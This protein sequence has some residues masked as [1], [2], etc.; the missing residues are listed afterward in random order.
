MGGLIGDKEFGFGD[1]VDVGLD[2][3]FNRFTVRRFYGT[4]TP[5]IKRLEK[6]G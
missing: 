4:E 2:K 1:V 5:N 3:V 6:V